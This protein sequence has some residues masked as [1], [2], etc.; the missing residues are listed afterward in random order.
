MLLVLPA[1]LLAVLGVAVMAVV[2]VLVLLVLVLL[3]L[4]LAL[5]V[6]LHVLLGA[7]GEHTLQIA[8]VTLQ[9]ASGV[10]VVGGELHM[11][12]TVGVLSNL[13]GDLSQVLGG[14]LNADRGVTSL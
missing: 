4:L 11:K 6:Y 2:I 7:V 3:A 10:G 12:R 14:Q 1:A 13:N 9:K 8:C 5:N